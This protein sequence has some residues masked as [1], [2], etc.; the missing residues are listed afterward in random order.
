MEI[1]ELYTKVNA[2]R[3][4]AGLPKISVARWTEEMSV[5]EIQD[6]I[7]NNNG[8]LEINSEAN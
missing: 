8:D 6:K 7:V 4:N 3:L 1:K 2:K 5:L